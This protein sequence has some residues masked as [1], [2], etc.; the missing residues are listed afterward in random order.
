[1]DPVNIPAKFEVRGFTLSSDNRGVV[2]KFEQSLDTS[3]LP[4]LPNCSR[5]F[6]RMEPRNIASKFQ[7][8][9]ALRIPEIIE[10]TPEIWAV[11]GYVQSPF[12]AKF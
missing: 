2:K 12:S 1:M 6:V 11:D 5:T 8:R 7:V 9:I 4:F 3:T 10:G